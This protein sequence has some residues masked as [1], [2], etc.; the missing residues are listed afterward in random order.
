MKLILLDPHHPKNIDG[1]QRMCKK[2][3]IDIEITNNFKRCQEENYN[4]LISNQKFF[5]PDLVPLSIK[6][7][8]GPQFFPDSEIVGNNNMLY[9]NRCVYNSLS[10]WVCN[11]V[12]DT[13]KQ[14]IIP[15]QQFPYAVDSEKFKPFGEKTLDCIVYFKHRN[16]KV[17]QDIKNILHEKQLSYKVFL[18][19]S[20]NEQE[21]LSHLQG[22]KFMIT[23]DAH[24]S[25]GFALQEAMSCNVPLLVFDIETVYDEYGST[26][27][28][29]YKPLELKATSVPYWDSSCGLRTTDISVIPAMID[30]M[31][32]T[33]QTF[34]PRKFIIENLSEEVCMKRILDW[35]NK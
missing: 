17:L 15:I 3:N 23:L 33:H 21:Y 5:N 10:K 29:K 9:S 4:I 11:F 27:F 18:Y 28:N 30:Q 2:M 14:L 6:I 19:G 13:S 7:I 24:E 34:E 1:I 31:L 32:N 16:P 25:Q 20:Y 22:S 8:Y 35:Y 26:F 12:L